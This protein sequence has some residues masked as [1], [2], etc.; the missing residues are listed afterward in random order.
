MNSMHLHINIATQYMKY[1]KTALLYSKESLNKKKNKTDYPD[2]AAE[3]I[4]K[5][6]FRQYTKYTNVLKNLFID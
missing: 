5:N 4:L 3:E 2:Y 1:S 6:V